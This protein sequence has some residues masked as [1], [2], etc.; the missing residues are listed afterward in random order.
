MVFILYITYIFDG[1]K[2]SEDIF[3]VTTQIYQK[4]L[5]LLFI[6]FY[7]S[8][9]SDTQNKKRIPL[10][11]TDILSAFSSFDFGQERIPSIQLSERKSFD[12]SGFYSCVAEIPLP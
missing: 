2:N 1:I 6:L 5:L 12:S 7:K 4:T 8:S 11:A 10:D 3:Y 9:E